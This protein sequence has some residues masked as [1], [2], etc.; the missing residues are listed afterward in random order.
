MTQQ[1]L[2]LRHF[3]SIFV[4]LAAWLLFSAL[5]L[6][7]PGGA[8]ASFEPDVGGPSMVLTSE[9]DSYLDMARQEIAEGDAAGALAA[10]AEGLVRHPDDFRLLERRADILAT[11]PGFQAQAAELYQQLLRARPDDLGLKI[12]LAN[13]WLA[14]RQPFLAEAQFQEVLALDPANG[15]ANLGLGRIY[16]ATAFFPMAARHFAQARASLPESRPALEGWRQASSLITPQIQT[17]ANAFEDAEGFRRTSFWVGFWDY[18]HPRLRFGCGYG[19]INYHS[20]FAFFQ[21]NK[22]GQ[23]LHRHIVPVVFQF[24]PATRVYLEAGGA[25]NDYG[26]WGQSGTG[27]VAAYWQATR[28]TGL[29]LTYS[30]HDVIE[31]F[32]P[33]RGPWGQFFDDFAGYGRY[34]YRIANPIS[35][36][37]QNFFGAGASNTLA[38]TRKIH[39]H[40]LIPWM[41]QALGEKLLLVAMCDVSFQSDGN[42]RQIWSPSLQYRILPDPLLKFKY[43][44]SYG[45]YLYPATDLAPP[46]T[47]PAYMAFQNLK[48]HAWGVVLEKNWG[49]RVKFVLESNLTYNQRSN[50]PG[51]NSLVELAYLLTHHVSLR[52][53]GFYSNALI[54]GFRSHQVRSAL[55]TVSYR[56]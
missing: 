45:D 48:Y 28:G 1:N 44:F 37:S 17:M 11:Q 46:G 56:F 2:Q 4:N 15:Q 19:Y 7:W 30:Y 24:R 32:G 31:F 3:K 6:S 38:V 55:A 16:L 27:R 26:R 43:S 35:L 5:L 51:F 54:E 41:Y 22:E 8:G 39:T 50:A 18:L 13:L 49:D 14:L 33:F 29:S 23:N 36:W 10:V 9:V 21:R 52:L 12:K 53:V 42:F 40:D 25:L 34:R 47:S 20:G